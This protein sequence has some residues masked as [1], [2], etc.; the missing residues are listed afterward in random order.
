MFTLRLTFTLRSTVP[1]AAS[2]YV[3]RLPDLHQDDA[4]PLHMFSGHISADLNPEKHTIT[5]VTPHL[6][7][8]MVKNRRT[9]DRDRVMFWF[10]VSAI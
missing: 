5:D 8:F 2:F 3:S 9:A 1:S 7:F 10:N 4:H 6:F